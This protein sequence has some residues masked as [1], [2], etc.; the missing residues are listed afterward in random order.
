MRL[1]SCQL[2]TCQVVCR[3]A[4]RP[5][6]CPSKLQRCSMA[7]T[8]EGCTARHAAAA[9]PAATVVFNTVQLARAAACPDHACIGCHSVSTG[10]ALLQRRRNTEDELN[11]RAVYQEGD[12]I[13]VSLCSV[14]AALHSQP[15]RTHSAQTKQPCPRRPSMVPSMTRK[16]CQAEAVSGKA[17]S[18]RRPVI[19][20]SCPFYDLHY[21]APH[22]CR[23]RFSPS[24]LTAASPCTPAASSM[25]RWGIG[26]CLLRCPLLQDLQL[27]ICTAV[28]LHYPAGPTLAVCT[29]EL[30]LSYVLQLA[31]GVL[32]EIP[33]KLI[34]RQKQHFVNLDGL[35]EPWKSPPDPAACLN[36]RLLLEAQSCSLLQ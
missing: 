4:G 21:P 31:E 10:F 15:R 30:H 22:A 2:S 23:Q 35:G 18:G 20:L 3:S 29:A 26:G 34:K 27:C 5:I 7:P 9:A 19:W 32:V 36:N 12:L 13:S 25:G 1:C 24:M 14:S 6:C 16:V 8:H 33:P 11:M 28:S 17:W